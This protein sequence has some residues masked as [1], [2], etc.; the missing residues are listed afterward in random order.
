MSRYRTC[1][2]K[3]NPPESYGDC[4]RACIASILDRDDVP[5][6]YD[7]RPL[8]EV[9]EATRKWLMENVGLA[10]FFTTLEADATL[11]EVLAYVATNNPDSF[12]LLMCQTEAGDHC[13]LCKGD[14][15]VHDPAWYRTAIK[16]AHS[17]GVW[18]VMVL[19]KV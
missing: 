12:Y 19:G 10:P 7:G 15:V 13:V 1:I 14:K 11:E 16:G 2:V 8:T 3:H 18:V 4:V 9:H 5:H 6:Y 17:L